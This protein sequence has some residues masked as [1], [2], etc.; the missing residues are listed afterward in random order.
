MAIRNTRILITNESKG[1]NMLQ[2][3]DTARQC[4]CKYRYSSHTEATGNGL[5]WSTAFGRDRAVLKFTALKAYFSA[6]ASVALRKVRGQK[7]SEDVSAVLM[8]RTGEEGEQRFTQELAGRSQLDSELVTEPIVALAQCVRDLQ[9]VSMRACTV[10]TLLL[11]EEQRERRQGAGAI[12][13]SKE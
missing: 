5:L 13:R 12:S 8:E 4:N 9:I 2:M 11:E 1:C 3:Y 7:N 10:Q 6:L